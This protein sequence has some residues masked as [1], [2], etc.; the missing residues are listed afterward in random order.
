MKIVAAILLVVAIALGALG[1][2]Q[3][4]LMEEHA[5]CEAYAAGAARKLQLA[6]AAGTPQAAALKSDADDALAGTQTVCQI[7]RE[8]KASGMM[9]GLG[10]LLSLIMSGAL[11]WL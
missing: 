9:L 2:Y 11:L 8:A 6:Q 4:F 5:L 7:A 1:G 10:G 3:D